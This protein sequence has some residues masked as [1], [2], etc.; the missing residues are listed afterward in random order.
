MF[1]PVSFYVT[2]RKR[3]ELL[4]FDDARLIEF[5]Q[6]IRRR[7]VVSVFGSWRTHK[8]KLGIDEAAPADKK[9]GADVTK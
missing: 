7:R 3:G 6:F 9:G 5:L 2:K 8:K 4:E 1:R